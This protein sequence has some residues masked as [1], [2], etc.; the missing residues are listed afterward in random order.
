M[1]EVV[2]TLSI[3]YCQYLTLGTWP[4]NHKPHPVPV[5][6]RDAGRDA[7]RGLRG[8]IQFLLLLNF[9]SQ[10]SMIVCVCFLTNKCW[11][12]GLSEW[13]TIFSFWEFFFVYENL[14]MKTIW[15]IPA[16]VNPLLRPCYSSPCNSYRPKSL[17][18]WRTKTT[19]MISSIGS[20]LV[21]VVVFVCLFDDGH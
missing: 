6:V 1:D 4:K 18:I 12:A 20:S 5:R 3:E 10:Y 14:N 9:N 13:F 15:Q 2:Y 11:L 16:T 17:K 19:V 8:P 21:F 7:M